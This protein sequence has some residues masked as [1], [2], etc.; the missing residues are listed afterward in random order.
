MRCYELDNYL[1]KVDIIA[2]ELV[3]SINK[4]MGE[5]IRLI[6]NGFTTENG[7]QVMAMCEEIQDNLISITNELKVL[8]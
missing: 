6:N 1:Y 8:K 7:K 5:C 4:N 3:V 2:D